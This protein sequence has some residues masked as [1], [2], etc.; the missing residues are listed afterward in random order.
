[1]NL[2]KSP[3]KDELRVLLAACDDNAG[4]H[5]IW[6][7][8]DGEVHIELL[9]EGLT[10]SHWAMRMEP[11]IKFRYETFTSGNGYVGSGASEDMKWVDTL[12]SWL[13]R[14]W[15]RDAHDYIE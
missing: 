10:P 1:M 6:V 4:H 3:S 14:D 9:P 7:S 12:F 8:H 5:C 13:Q 2:T 11:R 15:A